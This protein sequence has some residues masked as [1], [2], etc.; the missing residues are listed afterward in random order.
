VVVNCVGVVSST[1]DNR[2]IWMVSLKQC[3][4]SQ[5]VCNIITAWYSTYVPFPRTL[6]ALHQSSQRRSLGEEAT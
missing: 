1:T 6:V 4:R 3:K 2:C 5:S